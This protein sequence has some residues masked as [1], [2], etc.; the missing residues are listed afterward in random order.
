MAESS[1]P[2]GTKYYKSQC[3]AR[4][5]IRAKVTRVHGL[6]T[7]AQLDTLSPHKLD[8]YK[9]KLCSL[10][11]ELND[12]NRS[13]HGVLPDDVDED[14]LIIEEE[15][16]EDRISEALSLLNPPVIPSNNNSSV[17]NSRFPVSNKLSLPTI[18]MPIFSND[19]S[20]SLEKFF[21]AFESIIGKHNLSE[22]EKFVYLQ[23]QLRKG[24]H[25]LVDS[26]DPINQTYD[27]AKQLLTDAFASP[28]TQ[29]FDAIKK[30][31]ELKLSYND[32]I[33]VFISSMRNI[34]SS[35]SNLAIDVQTIM[36][37]YIW[38]A[39]NDRFQNQLIQI[40]NSTK[41]TLDEINE[42]IFEASERYI[43]L[44]DQISKRKSDNFSQ[45]N[46]KR[47][48]RS[49]M[50]T[51]NYAVNITK[52]QINCNLC[53]ADNSSNS[54]HNM[55][56]CI[57]YKTPI[58][59]VKKLESLNYCSHCSF[60][61]HIS[62]K[63]RFKFSSPCRNCKG[64]HLTYLCIDG[65]SNITKS[66]S[67]VSCVY[68][69]GN[70][71]DDNVI[72]PTFTM[73]IDNG[74]MHRE[75]RALY[76]TGSQ[77]NFVARHIID[78]LN[79]KVI[80]TNVMIS[81]HGFNSERKLSTDIVEIPILVDTTKIFVEAIVV[82]SIDIK[83]KIDNLKSITSDFNSKNYSL[84]D[85][86]IDDAFSVISNFGFVIGPDATK[87]L[88][89]K[90]ISFGS[91]INIG[92]SVYFE[93]NMGV[94]LLGDANEIRSNLSD[95]PSLVNDNPVLSHDPLSRE[96]ISSECNV[97]DRITNYVNQCTSDDVCVNISTVSEV[98]NE[99]GDLIQSR[100]DKATNEVLEQYSDDLLNY[101]TC[102]DQESSAIN[103]KLVNY[104]LSNTERTPEGRLI[105]PLPWN[106]ECKHLL[107]HNF[108]LSK[109]ILRSNFNKLKKNDNIM[110]YDQVFKEQEQL[111]IIERIEDVDHFIRDNPD[112]SFL[113]H[114]GIFRMK[115]ETTKVR[116]VYLSN[117]CEKNYL[118]PNAVSHNNALL[119][120]PCL[121]PKLFTALLLSRFDSNML[122]FDITKAFLGI[123]LN[124]C[125]Q[126]KLMCLWYKNV[127][128]GDYSLIAYKNLRLSF[129]LR[130]SPTILMLGLYKMFLL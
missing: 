105:M 7:S 83:L 41:P 44:N 89:P 62:S 111:G 76:D 129:G 93:T 98:L 100:L 109:K 6:V 57:K 35:F 46:Y 16:Y 118:Q 65:G 55:R 94:M 48:E 43:K 21:F 27:K 51:N 63:C 117:L 24:P 8:E 92:K 102:N 68:F 59:K 119:P 120:G 72:L 121:N 115:N 95:L 80:K 38:N 130:P 3:K 13:I 74:D 71:V 75:C 87:L 45:G 82:P 73:N 67:N 18:S 30:L 36:Q 49:P 104:I 103:E 31:S 5:Y 64:A 19:K 70:I 33:Y 123:Q 91:D 11:L 56:D 108:N 99:N 116:I 101:D 28:L 53:T 112:C 88:C 4:H 60:R 66:T 26:L 20:D 17:V 15:L 23:G 114:M 106:P 52:P 124:E 78:D 2:N 32:D 25:A 1:S 84:A 40:T 47:N 42:C 107:G 9:D 85:K 122:I 125:D 79:L 22:Y 77:R 54:N 110:L 10:K 58:E 50:K 126:N 39:F 34:T 127:E 37:Y 61:N 14:A 69:N 128:K 29:K 96:E 113:P 81:I 97:N 12:L 86:Y 90:T